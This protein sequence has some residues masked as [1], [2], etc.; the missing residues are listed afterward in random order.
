MGLL[1]GIKAAAKG[2]VN[3]PLRLEAY[4]SDSIEASLDDTF[5]IGTRLSTL[6]TKVGQLALDL[7]HL[8]ST[9]E[10]LRID[11][12]LHA[13][14]DVSSLGKLSDVLKLRLGTNEAVLRAPMRIAELNRQNILLQGAIRDLGSCTLEIA[15]RE[16]R[17]VTAADVRLGVAIEPIDI[18]TV[19]ATQVGDLNEL[20]Q[21]SMDEFIAQYKTNI[22]AQLVRKD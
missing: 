2:A 9:A 20:L 10:V 6:P 13:E 17:A 12:L 18:R 11:D 19:A 7:N 3:G 16:Q 1:R 8:H 4:A 21:G 22:H 15:L 5:E 14:V